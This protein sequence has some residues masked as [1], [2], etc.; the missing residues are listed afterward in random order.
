MLIWGTRAKLLLSKLILFKCA[1]CGE[2]NQLFCIFQKYLHLFW[3]PTIPF[4]KETILE[5]QNCK[6]VLEKHEFSAEL[7][8]AL[9]LEN[10]TPSA[11]FWMYSGLA[12]IVFFSVYFYIEDLKTEQQTKIY[13]SA[14]AKGD[15]AILKTEG[16]YGIIK[17]QLINENEIQFFASKYL[18]N[19]VSKAKKSLEKDSSQS[20]FFSKENYVMSLEKYK[21][22]EIEYVNR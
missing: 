11:P 20:D 14:P 22:G 15:V 6:K 1:N 5:C 21:S 8:T 12:L 7:K 4:G 2:Q 17:L 13:I 19:S 16:K 3:I 9:N 18:Y 10:T